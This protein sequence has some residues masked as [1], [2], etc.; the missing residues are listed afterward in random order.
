MTADRLYYTDSYLRSFDARVV[1]REE[2]G[3]RVYLD[4]TAFYPTS[5]GQPHDLG[6]L[7]GIA[8]ADVVD[9]GE[10]VAH[11]LAAP[12]PGSATTV[13]GDVDW[14]RRFD[15][16]Q[17]HTGQHLLSA[18]FTEMF[19]VGTVS[20]HFGRDTS[21]LDV[22]A[23]NVSREQLVRIEARANEIVA[24]N[25]AVTVTF[26]SA[27][28]AAGLRKASARE[29]TLRIVSIADLDRSAC[30][31]THVRATGAIGVVLVRGIEKIRK[32]TRIEFVC[33]GRAVRRARADFEALSRIAAS[34][35]ASLDDAPAVVAAR[36]EEQKAAANERRRL[37]RTVAEYRARELYDAALVR[38][39]GTR[40]VALR[41]AGA[42]SEGM[43]ALAQAFIAH[44][45]A[46]LVAAIASPPSVL[47]AASEDSGVDA[48]RLV[49]EMLAAHGGR[50]GGSP[51]LA[52]GSLPD[53]GTLTA[54]LAS[55]DG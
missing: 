26:E 7:G 39:D 18:L 20:V 46:V 38:G 33:G 24:E 41:E 14:P 25:R 32:S 53:E 6:T 42:T 23:E 54:V 51:R 5:G 29:G 10:R 35:S 13:R 45:K 36:S 28:E 31:G 19:G 2:E 3:R 43:R 4:R 12:L 37:E 47:V 22:D 30:G 17:Q 50:G 49:K 52:Q 8:I 9:E 48:G 15:H 16:M 21:S 34:L 55:L 44:P 11:L 1:A 27:A 40:R